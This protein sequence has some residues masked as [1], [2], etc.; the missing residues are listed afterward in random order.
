MHPGLRTGRLACCIWQL[1]VA[2]CG[3]R[4]ALC[5]MIGFLAVALAVPLIL[6][7]ILF[8]ARGP[9]TGGALICALLVGAVLDWLVMLL[10]VSAHTSQLPMQNPNQLPNHLDTCRLGL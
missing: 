1:Q 5:M 7:W 2:A 3:G 4:R 6:V 8:L 10:P 9:V